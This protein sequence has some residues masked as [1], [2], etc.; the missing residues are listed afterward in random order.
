M[1]DMVSIGMLVGGVGRVIQTSSTHCSARR[2]RT[3]GTD[4]LRDRPLT[5]LVVSITKRR[6]LNMPWYCEHM[7][8]VIAKTTVTTQ[9][10]QVAEPATPLHS[11]MRPWH[12]GTGAA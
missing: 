3:W 2:L 4:V 6:T 10:K 9:G 11:F 1:A 5:H 12:M 8:T 7:A